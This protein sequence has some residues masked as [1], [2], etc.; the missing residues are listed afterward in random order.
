MPSTADHCAISSAV[1]SVLPSSTTMISQLAHHCS[2]QARR[3]G[4]STR[5]LAASFRPGTTQLTCTPVA[6]S[7]ASTAM[8]AD[9]PAADVPAPASSWDRNSVYMNTPRRN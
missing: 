9:C 5:R 8:R 3:A 6:P 1:S 7:P 4:T 2:R